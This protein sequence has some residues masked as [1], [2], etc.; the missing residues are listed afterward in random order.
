MT[1]LAS[2]DATA[3]AELVRSGDA[4]PIE[5]VDAAIARIEKVNDELNAVIHPLF[6]RARRGGR[7]RRPLPDGPFRGVPIVVKDLDGT[8]AGAPYHGGNRLLK[9]LNYT[10]T[11]TS[12]VFAKLEAAGFVIVGK[13]NTPELGL[14]TDDR[15]AGVR[16]DAQP[17]GHDAHAGR[18]ERRLGGRGRERHGAARARG[19]RRRIDP[20]P[21]EHVR[22][23][24][25][26][27]VAGSRLARPR[28]SR[29]VERLRRCATS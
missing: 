1:D 14:M 29:G 16:P 6:D 28:R 13:T 3:Q 21:V 11:V 9:E 4:Q 8:L 2:L 18:L 25:V 19:R 22:A 15:A 27:A 10:P 24:R 12:H 26:E 20:H 7:E 23:L 17:V 5:L